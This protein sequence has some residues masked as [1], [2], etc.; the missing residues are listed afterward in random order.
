MSNLIHSLS[1]IFKIWLL[2]LERYVGWVLSTWHK[3]RHDWEEEVLIE[4]LPLLLVGKFMG[5]HHLIND[6]CGRAQLSVAGAAP[7]QLPKL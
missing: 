6:G 3:P 1:R 2:S 7:G 5:Q 4:K